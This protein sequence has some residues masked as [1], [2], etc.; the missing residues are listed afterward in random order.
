M[1]RTYERVVANARMQTLTLP[2]LTER[3]AQQ[4]RLAYCLAFIRPRDMLDASYESANVWDISE[5]GIGLFLDHAL[6]LGQ[7]LDLSFRYL[8]FRDR[9]AMVVHV[10]E[11]DAGWH[12][13]CK[14]NEP[15]SVMELRTLGAF[16]L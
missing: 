11:L 3:R 12:I 14:L 16:E 7:E 5:G 1:S 13:G 10:T 2:T 4:R 8:A 15:F 6:K 9:V